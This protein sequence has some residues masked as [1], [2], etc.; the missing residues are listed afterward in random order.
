MVPL[1]IRDFFQGV[2]F[3][4]DFNGKPVSLDTLFPSPS[5]SSLPWRINLFF[6][7]PSRCALKYDGVPVQWGPILYA[8]RERGG[9]V[10]SRPTKNIAPFSSL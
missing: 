1:F 5:G 7:R 10:V 2:I 4:F 3:G 8:A 9:L 6:I